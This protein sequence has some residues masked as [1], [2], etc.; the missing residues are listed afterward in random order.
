MKPILLAAFLVPPLAGGAGKAA[1]DR[2]VT[3]TGLQP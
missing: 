2:P 1:L 3:V